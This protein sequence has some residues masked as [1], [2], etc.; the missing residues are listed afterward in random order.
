MPC[1]KRLVALV[2]QQL[3]VMSTLLVDKVAIRLA[4]AQQ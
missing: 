2:A 4:Q 1:L 3:T